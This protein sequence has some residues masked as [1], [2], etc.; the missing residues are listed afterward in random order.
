MQPTLQDIEDI[1][2]ELTSSLQWMLENEV[3]DL[4][5]PFTYELNIFGINITQELE[6]NGSDLIV[7]EINKELYVS[8]LCMVKSLEENEEQIKS[9]K[10]GLFEIVPVDAMKVFSSG[11][12][13]ILIS[14]QP[15]VDVVDLKDHT[16]YGGGYSKDNKLIEWFWEIVESMDQAMLANLL[17]FITGNQSFRE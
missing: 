9:F 7:D 8:R 14:G 2:P 10:D 1:E 3:A 17:F 13:A 16:R 6:Q 11:E 5:Q 15:E 12:L 4:E